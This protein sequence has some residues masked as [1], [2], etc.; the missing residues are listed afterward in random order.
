MDKITFINEER[1]AELEEIFKKEILE[2][3]EK[4]ISKEDF[5]RAIRLK[6]TAILDLNYLVNKYIGKITII[7]EENSVIDRLK[8]VLSSSDICF[9]AE[10]TI[11]IT[12]NTKQK[13]KMPNIRHL[14]KIKK[15]QKFK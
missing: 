9:E 1:Q 8:E 13:Q 14:K 15:Y 6:T 3:R 5:I 7:V 11:D 2:L 12:Y 4:N 10:S